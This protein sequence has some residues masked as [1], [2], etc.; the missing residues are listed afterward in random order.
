MGSGSGQ[1]TTVDFP[2]GRS[3]GA[4]Y[5]GGDGS[6]TAG[7]A[8]RGGGERLQNASVADFE[9]IKR[10]GRAE[11]YSGTHGVGSGSHIP[12]VGDVG[13]SEAGGKDGRTDTGDAGAVAT[14][15]RITVTNA[16][17]SGLGGDSSWR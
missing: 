5:R 13:C 16:M 14:V 2:T 4:A 12:K 7:E 17:V 9:L 15:D 8:A 1:K 11:Y 3:L 10:A 6:G